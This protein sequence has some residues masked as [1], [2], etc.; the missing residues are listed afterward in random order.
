LSDLYELTMESVP[1]APVLVC[2]LDAW[3][4]AGFAAAAART[5][6]TASGRTELVARFDADQLVDHQARR[7]TM[8]LRDGVHGGIS[9]PVIELRHGSDGDGRGFLYLSGP[10]PDHR[11]RAISDAVAELAV[12]GGVRLLVSLGAYPAAVPHTR[13]AKVVATGTTQS[14]A[15]RIGFVP[16]QLE[17]P[18]GLNAAIEIAVAEAGIEACG[19]WA[20]VPHYVANLPYPAAATALIAALHRLTGITLDTSSLTTA[21][22]ETRRRL[23]DLVGANPEHLAMV[24]QLESAFDQVPGPTP[25]PSGDELAA[26]VEQFLRSH[27]E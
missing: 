19:L 2:G 1:R 10:E 7:P 20:Q 9:W 8:K 6:L 4:D 16:G 17:V 13:E 12:A 21:A 25:L 22:Q 26:E 18:A 24:R 14:I 15:D 27:D 23:D 5:A 3:I 11:W